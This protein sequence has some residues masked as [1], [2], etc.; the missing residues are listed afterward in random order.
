MKI[1]NGFVSNSSSSSFVAWGVK[2]TKEEIEKLYPITNE[3]DKEQF[4][5]NIADY[6]E[7]KLTESANKDSIKGKYLVVKGDG[8]YFGG[9]H[10]NVILAADYSYL[11]DG[12]VIGIDEPDKKAIV[13]QL[14]K[15][16]IN[17]TEQNIKLYVQMV[18]NDNY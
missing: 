10:K 13:E 5:D 11:E 17:T 4:E 6:V 9:T 16:G 12:E 3:T 1:R 14:A 7:G 8:N 18:S 2:L 15:W